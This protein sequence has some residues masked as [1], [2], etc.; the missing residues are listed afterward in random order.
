MTD[1][2]VPGVSD[3]SMASNAASAAAMSS[4]VAKNCRTTAVPWSASNRTFSSVVEQDLQF[5]RVDSGWGAVGLID[6]CL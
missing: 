5:G 2:R 3:A 1:V 6:P 4:A